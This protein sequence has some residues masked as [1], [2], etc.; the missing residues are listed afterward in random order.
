MASLQEYCERLPEEVLEDI[1]AGGL[2]AYPAEVIST[3]CHV[4]LKRHPNRLDILKIL[5]EIED[6]KQ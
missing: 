1:L 5:W 2:S 6:A 3:I 4:L